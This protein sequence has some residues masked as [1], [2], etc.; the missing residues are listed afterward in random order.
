MV[1]FRLIFVIIVIMKILSNQKGLTLI[2]VLIVLAILGIFAFIAVPSIT[3]F[4]V[5]A[6]IK[7]T[8]TEL[9]TIQSALELYYIE[10]KKYPDSLDEIVKE[11]FLGKEAL[12][13]GFG[14]PY[15][16]KPVYQN[17]QPNQ[18]YMLSSSGKDGIPFTDDDIP[19][20]AGEHKFK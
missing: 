6:K 11:K 12:N 9:S 5:T 8:E 20:P 4:L 2:E 17:N 3:R 13:D 16:Y 10:L 7:A 14:N 1:D 18:N 19:A 15:N